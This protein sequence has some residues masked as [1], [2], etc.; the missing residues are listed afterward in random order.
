MKRTL[1]FLI[2]SLTAVGAFLMNGLSKEVDLTFEVKEVKT[3]HIPGEPVLLKLILHNK[4]KEQVTLTVDDILDEGVQVKLSSDENLPITKVERPKPRG[5]MRRIWRFCP[6]GGDSDHLYILLDKYYILNE[7]GTYTGTVT[8]KVRDHA[9]LKAD[10]QV[11]I[12]EPLEQVALSYYE[13]W[14]T[15]KSVEDKNMAAE[16]LSHT[17]SN[18]A[19]KYLEKIALDAN[20]SDGYRKIACNGLVRIG[21]V[22]SAMLL[23]KLAESEKMPERFSY[24]CKALIV[25]W[26]KSTK[27]DEIKKATKEVAEK[28]P[29]AKIGET[30]D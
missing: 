17:R 22:N 8:V 6:A 28:Y 12:L 30:Y 18:H 15:G 13:R 10:F 11:I 7:P 20:A 19:I 27:D 16:L 4:G 21:T 9:D 23:V 1:L 5:G 29:N 2:V 14:R 25:A 24:H 26:H 3:T